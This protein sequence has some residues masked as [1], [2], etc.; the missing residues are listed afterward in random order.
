MAL[1]RVRNLHLHG[2]DH[3]VDNTEQKKEVGKGRGTCTYIHPSLVCQ[4]LLSCAIIAQLLLCNKSNVKVGA[5]ARD[6]IYV[7]RMTST[8]YI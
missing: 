2:P 4:P 8:T 3:V 5:G 6:Y 7:L 1:L